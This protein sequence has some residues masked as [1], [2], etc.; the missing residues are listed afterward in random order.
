M[1]YN[2]ATIMGLSSGTR[3]VIYE[4]GA[5]IGA[6]EMPFVAQPLLSLCG[7]S[8]SFVGRGFS[9]DLNPANSERLQPLR[10]GFGSCHT[11]SLLAIRG[12]RC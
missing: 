3:L 4:M 6:G 9:H 10:F 2:L 8:R 12:I 5:V 7:N 11:D 1:A